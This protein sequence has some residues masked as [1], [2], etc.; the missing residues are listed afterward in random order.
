MFAMIAKS[1]SSAALAVVS[2]VVPATRRTGRT[3][4]LVKGARSTK[5]VIPIK[6]P[7]KKQSARVVAL[8]VF[9]RAAVREIDVDRRNVS[10]ES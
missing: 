6:P 9:K 2:A 8:P 4:V 3:P 1:K 7:A 10:V 5:R